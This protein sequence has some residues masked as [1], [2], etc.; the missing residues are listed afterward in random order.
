[1]II[2]LYKKQITPVFII[3]KFYTAVIDKLLVNRW[4]KNYK[5]LAISKRSSY[6]R[7]FFIVSAEN[8]E[9]P[10]IICFHSF[11]RISIS[12]DTRFEGPIVNM[13][14]SPTIF[15]VDKCIGCGTFVA[16]DERKLIVAQFFCTD[17][18]TTTAMGI[19]TWN[20]LPTFL[21]RQC[22]STICSRYCCTTIRAVEGHCRI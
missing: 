16:I 14:L 9:L 7:L 1:M 13:S 4:G 10:V 15:T 22:V 20:V 8:A 11:C 21:P 5:S 12:N 3:W 6:G 2:T 18:I 17:W 19:T